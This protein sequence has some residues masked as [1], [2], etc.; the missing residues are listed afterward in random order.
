LQAPFSRTLFD[1]LVEQAART[2]DALAVVC[3]ERHA[4]YAELLRRSRRVAAGLTARGVSRGDRVGAV[5]ANQLEWL[6]LCFGTAAAGATFVP[7]STWSTR[8]EL[9]FL[10]RDSEIKLLVSAARLGD[11][12]YAADLAELLPELVLG[13]SSPRFP[14]LGAIL[15]LEALESDVFGRFE[16]LLGDDTG[17]KDLAPGVTAGAGDD[18]LILYTSGSSATPKAVRLKHFGVVENGFNIGERMG[19]GPTDRIFLS[20]P[21]F[22]SYGSANALPAALTHGGAVV[23]QPRFDAARA[24]ELIERHRCTAIYTLPAM[25]NAILGAP[26]YARDRLSTLRTGLTIGT[27]Q[28]FMTAARGLGA[29]ELCNIYGTTETYGNCCVTSH[30]WPLERRAVCQ[31]EPLPGNELRLVDVET[32]APVAP[33]EAG[34]CEVHGYITPG[35]AG[36]SAEQN[37]STFTPDGFYRTGDIGRFDDNG[38]FVFVG[39]NTEMLKRAGINVS[40]AEVETILRGHPGVAEAGVVGVPDVERGELVIAFVVT[41]E[42]AVTATELIAHCRSTAS[43]YKV[44]DRIEIRKTLPLTPTGKLQRRELKREAAALV[45]EGTRHG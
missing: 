4:S 25:T 30:R 24:I 36:A 7:F 13:Q 6:E 21:L 38:A 27:P 20:A 28:D 23:L 34:L 29:S 43:K 19:L 17:T 10:I 16:A 45:S 32:G 18:A 40:P 8:S 42:P 22:W 5:L 26:G 11:R 14:K 37:A 33:G 3:R 2:P 39:R 31:G 9:D 1:L 41:T 12:D 35:Y 15:L 44:P